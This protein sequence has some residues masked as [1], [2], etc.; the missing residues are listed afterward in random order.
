MV[1][2]SQLHRFV[3]AML[4]DYPDARNVVIDAAC[5]GALKTER[6]AAYL[7]GLRLADFR[8]LA[9]I[10]NEIAEQHTIPLSVRPLVF[11]FA[12]AEIEPRGDLLAEVKEAWE[13][14][15]AT[16]ERASRSDL[17]AAVGR[18]EIGRLLTSTS[19][20]EK[21]TQLFAVLAG[22][23][24]EFAAAI[25]EPCAEQSRLVSA[26][27]EAPLEALAD[28][29]A[30]A[31]DADPSLARSLVDAI[32]GETAVIERIRADDPWITRLEVSERDNGLVGV[33]RFLYASASFP[34]RSRRAGPQPGADP[35]AV[36]TQDRVSRRP[37][38]PPRRPRAGQ[39]RPCLLG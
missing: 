29:V 6:V 33:A 38:P 35:A 10:W 17:A 28:C 13:A 1:P 7:Q 9:T 27:R 37:S 3:A 8:E 15:V 12:I 31:Y 20:T 32:G 4:S 22:V 16:T 23:G 26:L 30:A 2:T 19:D 11:M 14:M 39:R 34:A 24:A 18:D 5:A 36:P 25:A 21:A